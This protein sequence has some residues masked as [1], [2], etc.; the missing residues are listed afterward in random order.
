[1]KRN[2]QLEESEEIELDVLKCIKDKGEKA[3]DWVVVTKLSEETGW[4][5][6]KIRKCLAYLQKMDLAEEDDGIYKITKGGQKY[7]DELITKRDETSE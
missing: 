5:E 7:L 2:M 3:V 1:M 6:N 4:A